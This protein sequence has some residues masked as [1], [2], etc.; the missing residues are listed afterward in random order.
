MTAWVAP[1]RGA[2]G[3][4]WEAAPAWTVGWAVLLIVQGAVP[5]AV[6]ALT[7]WVVDAVSAAIGAGAT[8]ETA[9]SVLVP[10]ALMGGLMLLQRVLGSVNDWVSTGQSELVTD[11]IKRLIHEKAASVEF[12]FYESSSYHDLLEQVNSQASG[13]TLQLLQNTGSLVRSTVTFVS[14][15]GILLAYGVWIPL[16]LIVSAAPAFAIVLRHNRRF[17]DW[18]NGTTPDRRLAHYFDLVLTQAMMAAEVRIG[19]LGPSF[20]ERYQRIRAGLRK[21]RLKLLRDQAIARLGAAVIALVVTAAVMGWVVW[22]ALRGEATIGDL[23]LFYSAFTQGQSLMGGVLQ[24]AGS[25]YTNTLFLNHLFEFLQ[26][27]TIVE[28]DA[29]PVP[30]PSPIREGVRFEDVTFTYPGNDEPALDGFSLEIPA[31]TAVAVV[32]ENGAGKSTFIKLLCRFYDPDEGRLTVDGVDLKRFALDDL[33]RRIA[34]LFQMP[35]RYQLTVAENLTLGDIDRPPSSERMRLAAE[36][37]G[38]A[39][40]V[41]DLPKAY[42]TLLGRWF[43]GG[44]E[45]SGG[46]WQRIALARAFYRESPLVVLDEPTSFMDSWAENEWLDRYQRMV[47]GRTS[48]VI[49]HRFTTAMRADVIHVMERGRIVES[50]THEELLRLGGRYATSWRTQMREAGAPPGD[51]PSGDGDASVSYPYA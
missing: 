34:V 5:A 12:A 35:V 41:G 2:L 9:Q 49:T 30:F 17:H 47:A 51:E 23:A 27:E 31:G 18:W 11:H 1:A 46:Q 40:F 29:A 32:G 15:A 4:I 22:S 19:H 45:L 8:W 43:E 3:L 36:A 33:R 28:E 26:L 44:R 50:G 20:T 6:V 25:V 48:L 7:K 24:S 39:E 16:A 21:A 13:R 10:A 42:D 14:I 37:A 38:A